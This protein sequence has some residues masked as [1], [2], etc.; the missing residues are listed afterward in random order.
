LA[1]YDVV[2]GAGGPIH[3]P[4]PWSRSPDTSFVVTADAMRSALEKAGFR[5]TLWDD[6]T[7]QAV[8][9]FAEQQLARAA[10]QAAGAPANPPP[11]GLHIAMGADFPVLSGNLGRNLR[12]GRVGILQAIVERP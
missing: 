6:R 12:E 8:A 9:W 11:L 2:L 3:Y 10:A 4:V 7:A 1:I 5:V